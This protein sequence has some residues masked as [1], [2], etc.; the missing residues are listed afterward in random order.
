MKL[1][2]DNLL[3]HFI[4]A[5]ALMEKVEEVVR[6]ARKYSVQDFQQL[7]SGYTI[8]NLD[9]GENATLII[10]LEH[11]RKEQK[12]LRIPLVWLTLSKNALATQFSSLAAKQELERRNTTQKSSL[13]HNKINK[14]QEF[15][16]SLTKLLK[17]FN[18]K[19]EDQSN[20]PYQDSRPH[21]YFMSEDWPEP[22][23]WLDVDNLP[24]TLAELALLLDISDVD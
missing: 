14:E 15:L 11:P 20:Y 7:T 2:I 22:N 10:Y 13:I 24:D 23:I 1:T 9:A 4:Y 5:E 6:L 8:T 21:I 12:I 3:Q 16:M 19:V 18:I 17:D